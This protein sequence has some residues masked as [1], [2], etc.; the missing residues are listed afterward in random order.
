MI[1]CKLD[2][3]FVHHVGFLNVSWC[4]SHMILNTMTMTSI[5]SKCNPL[6]MIYL[7]FGKEYSM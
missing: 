4:L 5:G 7:I 1:R 2:H 3:H 6:K